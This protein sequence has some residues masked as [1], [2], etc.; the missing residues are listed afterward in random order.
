MERRGFLGLGIVS[1]LCSVLGI[2]LPTNPVK[3]GIPQIGDPYPYPPLVQTRTH[4]SKFM[5][6]LNAKENRGYIH[7]LYKDSSDTVDKSRSY[8][9][10]LVSTSWKK[11]FNR[12][13]PFNDEGEIDFHWEVTNHYHLVS[14][15]S[16]GKVYA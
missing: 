5:S 15:S 16:Y 8:P 6:V 7:W 10:E 9:Y 13:K 12:D 3:C 2:R 11:D 14:D 4:I 1:G